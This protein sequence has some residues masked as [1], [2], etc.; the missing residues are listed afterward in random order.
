MPDETQVAQPAVRGDT[1]AEV[2]HWKAECARLSILAKNR[3]KG[4]KGANEELAALRKQHADLVEQHAKISQ[5]YREVTHKSEFA[6]AAKEAGV[7]PDYADDL[8]ALSGYSPTG[9]D[10]DPKAISAAIA[11]LKERRPRYF[12]PAKPADPKPE[13]TPAPDAKEGEP[14]PTPEPAPA[15]VAGPPS[16]KGATS[17]VPGAGSDPASRRAQ[18]LAA[19]GTPDILRFPPAE[20]AEAYKSVGT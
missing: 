7:D 13:E 17:G 19:R 16:A 5:R 12:Q 3:G 14:A 8:W 10:P 2:N 4:A 18:I 1:F 15:P 11:S 20:V 6:R 9:D